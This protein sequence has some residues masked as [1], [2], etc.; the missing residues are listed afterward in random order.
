ME[1]GKILGNL[2]RSQEAFDQFGF[3]EK[4]IGEH[5]AIHYARGTTLQRVFK[6]KEASEWFQKAAALQ[7]D[8]RILRGLATAHGS[9]QD[10]YNSLL[11]AQKGLAI[12]PRDPDLLRNQ[13][14]AFRALKKDS[15][16]AKAATEVFGEF[17]HDTLAPHIHNKC[18]DRDPACKQGRL[19]IEVIVLP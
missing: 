6:T 9:A 4:L 14:V 18:A 12:E 5:P 16:E 19:P 3:A 17:Q 15:D 10:M 13:M 1:Q 7:E 11:A 2:G 8:D